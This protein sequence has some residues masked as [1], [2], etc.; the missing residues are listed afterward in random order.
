VDNGW[1]AG[2]DMWRDGLGVGFT[3]GM[4]LGGKC[5]VYWRVKDKESRDSVLEGSSR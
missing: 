2:M 5:V 1:I 4:R 3:R